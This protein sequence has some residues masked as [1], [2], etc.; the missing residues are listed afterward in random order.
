MAPFI[1]SNNSLDRIRTF[2]LL[3]ILPVLIAAVGNTGYQYLLARAARSG[4]VPVTGETILP[5]L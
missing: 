2:R 5:V 3:A 4:E 1:R